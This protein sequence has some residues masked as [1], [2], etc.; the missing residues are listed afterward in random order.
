MKVIDKVTAIEHRWRQGGSCAAIGRKAC[1]LSEW[2]RGGP[3]DSEKLLRT[4]SR[5]NRK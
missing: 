1:V 2:D 5:T 4:I 3:H